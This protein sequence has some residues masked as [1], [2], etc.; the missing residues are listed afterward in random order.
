MRFLHDASI[1]C[2]GALCASLLHSP[3]HGQD[4]FATRVV[5]FQQ[6]PGGGI[7]DP[8]NALGG[9][10][11]GGR[12]AGSLDVLSLGAGGQVTLGFDVVITDGPGAD[13][14][15]FENA[16]E[17]G[18]RV[19]AEAL[20][21]EVST[22]GATFARF[23]TRYAGPDGPLGAFET[24][25]YGSF[26]G[27]AGGVPVLANVDT[28]PLDPFDPV[29]AGGEAFDLEDLAGD[30]HV[31]SGAV[32]LGSIHF[33]R[34]VDVVGG[35]VLDARGRPI[36]D[37]GGELGSAD[38]DAVA[39]IQHAANQDPRG[40][41]VEARWTPAG[42][43]RLSLSDPDGLADVD[44]PLDLRAAIDSLEVPFRALLG[45]FLFAPSRLPL[46][47]RLVSSFSSLEPDRMLVLS[48]SMTD[49]SGSR[50]VEQIVISP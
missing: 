27:L 31:A 21:V 32:D 23:A 13:L 20:L 16:F 5:D 35:T 8:L 12:G 44:L 36:W 22:D 10:R 38:V 42:H 39:V 45:D 40:P 17:A 6:G 2:A 37:S 50:S 14:S 43:V 18:G 33:V 19:F 15:V 24:L 48:V 25:P 47:W 1:V 3:A 46:E 26:A 4:R 29:E 9:P 11:G 49:R 28:N 34:L 41:L 7:F 30:P